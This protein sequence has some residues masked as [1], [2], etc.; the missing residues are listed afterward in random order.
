MISCEKHDYVEIAC[1]YNYL[2]KLTLNSGDELRGVAL[3]VKRNQNR[4]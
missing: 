3:D 1:M 4:E 2:I